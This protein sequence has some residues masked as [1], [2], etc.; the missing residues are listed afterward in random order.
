MLIDSISLHQQDAPQLRNLLVVPEPAIAQPRSATI[1]KCAS[2]GAAAAKVT[3]RLIAI[4]RREVCDT[5]C[6]MIQ[7]TLGFVLGR[8]KFVSMIVLPSHVPFQVPEAW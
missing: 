7:L 5:V 8:R 1:S 3:V 2:I 4:A 6:T